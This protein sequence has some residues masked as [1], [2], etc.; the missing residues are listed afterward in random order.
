MAKTEEQFVVDPNKVNFVNISFPQGTEEVITKMSCTGGEKV[1][2]L[3]V[4][5]RYITEDFTGKKMA[6]PPGWETMLM[7]LSLIAKWIKEVRDEAEAE[8]AK[9]DK[10]KGKGKKK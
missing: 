8:K 3:L 1:M 10:P 4:L 2:A 6:L 7:S 9:A 5:A